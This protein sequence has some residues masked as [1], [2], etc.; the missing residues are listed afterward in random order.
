MFSGLKKRSMQEDAVILFLDEASVRADYLR[1]TTWAKRGVT[2]VVSDTGDRFSIDLVSASLFPIWWCRRGFLT[3]TQEFQ[4]M[5]SSRLRRK[6]RKE[7][8]GRRVS[9][10][11]TWDLICQPCVPPQFPQTNADAI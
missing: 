4:L 5:W 3:G 2:P 10:T 9:Y 8:S 7:L 6:G 1:G 11:T